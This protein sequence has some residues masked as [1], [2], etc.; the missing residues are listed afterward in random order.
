MAQTE[1]GGLTE[2]N[3]PDADWQIVATNATAEAQTFDG[4][5]GAIESTISRDVAV[6]PV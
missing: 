1:T 5:V 4:L 2:R 3:L 6:M